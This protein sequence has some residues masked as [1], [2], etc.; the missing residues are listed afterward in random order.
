MKKFKLT[1]ILIVLTLI[2]TSC[3]SPKEPNVSENNVQDKV[4]SE[5]SQPITIKDSYEREITFEKSPEKA[6]CIGPGALRL[7]TYVMNGEKLIAVED[8]EKGESV[9]PYIMANPE[10]KELQTAGPGGPRNEPDAENLSYLEPEVIFST[11]G[12]SKEDLDQLQE[13]IGVPVV[14]IG[15]GKETIFEPETNESIENIGKIMGK[16]DRANEVVSYMEG[17][18]EDLEKRAGKMDDS[19]K[20]Y[21]GCIGF[22]GAQGILS[23]RSKF[24]LFQ[25]VN[26]KNIVDEI[27]EERNIMLDKE[28]LLELNPEIIFLD[29]D[30]ESIL[31]NDY[32]NDPNFYNTLN[33]FKENKVYALMPY[34]NYHTNIDTSLID[35]YYIGSIIHSENFKD[36]DIAKKASEIYT[37]LLG[38]DVYE[39]ML[40]KY[41]KSFKE[42]SFNE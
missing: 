19:P 29:L 38:K 16:S 30:G 4:E 12:A 13:K 26:V 14:G 21:I 41:P 17:I 33:A 3:G 24:N 7:Y 40:N 35:M 11:Y 15:F 37:S 31:Q 8:T 25:A 9:N 28:K 36:V 42:Y 18:K 1:L 20:T 27:T 22:R 32:K 23:S 39:E 34:N 6:I 5:S 2:I 10:I